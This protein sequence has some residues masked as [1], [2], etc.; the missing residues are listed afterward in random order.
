MCSSLK[1]FDSN[2]I[3]DQR[4]AKYLNDGYFKGLGDEASY[5]AILYCTVC[6]WC[7]EREG[8]RDEGRDALDVMKGSEFG[9]SPL[10]QLLVRPRSHNDVSTWDINVVDGLLY[11][12]IIYWRRLPSEERGLGHQVQVRGAA[13][14]PA[15]GANCLVQAFH[16]M[17]LSQSTR[18][19]QPQ[20]TKNAPRRTT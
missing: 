11:L 7:F 18:H 13:H 16:F 14:V 5:S 2:S 8:T 10:K 9:P 1:V 17:P 6:G 20:A 4:R 19:P 15:R 3:R 12:G